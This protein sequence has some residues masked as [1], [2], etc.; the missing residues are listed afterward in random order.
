MRFLLE[1]GF[2]FFSVRDPRGK[3]TRYPETLA[4][5]REFVRRY[6]DQAWEPIV[7]GA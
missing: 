2:R 7:P 4:E 6:R 1:H 5:A 3:Y